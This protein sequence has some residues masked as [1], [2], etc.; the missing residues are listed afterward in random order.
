MRHASLRDLETI[1]KQFQS[2]RDVFPHIRQDKLKRQIGAKQCI[3]QDGVVITY[4]QYKKRT[5]VG[6]VQ[7][8]AGA[9]MLHQILNSDQFNGAG[10]RVFRNFVNEIVKR[11]GGDLYL[12]VRRENR[13]AC[14]FY[15]RQGM[16][17]AGTVAWK[18]GTIPGRVY[19]LVNE[20]YE[21]SSEFV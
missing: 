5:H 13:V 16:R 10:R 6:N 8:P 2:R 3:Y 11:S 4:Q 1:Y 7:M 15:E 21:D 17:V 19:R 9:I 14:R 18:Q 12:T 20:E